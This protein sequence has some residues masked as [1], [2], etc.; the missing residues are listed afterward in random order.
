MTITTHCT[1]RKAMAKTIAEHLGLRAEYLGVP[2]CA[3]GIGNIR[4]ER[5]GSL[6]G[7]EDDLKALVPFLLEHGFVTESDLQA[8][9]ES[10]ASERTEEHE[11]A[12]T[13]FE[14]TEQDE[15]FVPDEPA[16]LDT[17]EQTVHSDSDVQDAET[18]D[19]KA[20]DSESITHTCISIS[21]NEFTPTGMCNLLKLLYARQKLIDLMTQS[22]CISVDEE[23]LTLLNDSRPDTLEKISELVISEARVNMIRGIGI[24][25]HHLTLEF[26]YDEAKPTQWTAYAALMTAMVD[27]AK[28]S[29][30]VNSAML[31]PKPEETKYLCHSFL[32]QLG[33]RGS[34]HA[35]TRH[36]LL[37]HLQ[38]YAAFK[39]NDRMEAHKA[40]V[41]QRR[42]EA[43]EASGSACE[44]KESI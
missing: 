10:A 42:R 15:Y 9:M 6:T 30:H 14:P 8:A 19:E 22:D 26:P 33:M 17:L 24:S 1:D 18:L 36:I 28:A 13:T 40:R 12:A 29:R 31:I 43:R 4:V 2:S 27:R 23:V 20:S 11:E 5:D 25:D 44:N 21:L 39:S 32:M 34:E 41:S 3:Y 38:G 37:D 16:A 7:T 35:E